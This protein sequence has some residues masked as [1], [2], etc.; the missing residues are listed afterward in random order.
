MGKP[1]SHTCHRKLSPFI[2]RLYP[3]PPS[4]T[5]KITPA[6]QSQPTP[7]REGPQYIAHHPL[8][9]L[10]PLQKWGVCLLRQMSLK[11]GEDGAE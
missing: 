1:N 6:S 4:H 11:S 2:W 5:T 10:Q 3:P 9:R 8:P 7:S